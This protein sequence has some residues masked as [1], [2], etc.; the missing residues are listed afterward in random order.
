MLAS[1]READ[2]G[3][4]TASADKAAFGR[5]DISICSADTEREAEA[6]AGGDGA[7]RG[8][9]PLRKVD[10]VSRDNFSAEVGDTLL[11]SCTQQVAALPPAPSHP[12][13][14]SPSPAS[15]TSLIS[16]NSAVL[17]REGLENIKEPT[18]RGLQGRGRKRGVHQPER[19][20]PRLDFGVRSQELLA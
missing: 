13:P 11:Q 4:L 1:V 10:I 20:Y 18:S 5:K 15:F 14:L 3:S 7:E 9:L 6:V 16:C 12:L 2:Q 8:A 19:G 17:I